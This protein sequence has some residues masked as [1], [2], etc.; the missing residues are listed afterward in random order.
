MYISTAGGTSENK[1]IPEI[2]VTD[3]TLIAIDICTES[4]DNTKI[5][6]IY[7]DGMKISKEQLSKASTLNKNPL[8]INIF[9]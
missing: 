2:L 1:K 5:S 8:K 3:E 7:V 4:F 9:K 6:Y